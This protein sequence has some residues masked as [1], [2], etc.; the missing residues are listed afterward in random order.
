MPNNFDL[1][2]PEVVSHLSSIA[3]KHMEYLSHWAKNMPN[4]TVAG[5]NLLEV[6]IYDTIQV[7]NNVYLKSYIG[8]QEKSETINA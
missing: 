2:N 7:L 4:V 8:S 6:T 5:V 3:V 1:D